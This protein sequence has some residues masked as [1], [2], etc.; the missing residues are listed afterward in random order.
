MVAPAAA[1]FPTLTFLRSGVV[2]W[3]NVASDKK[4]KILIDFLRI[5][6]IFHHE[7]NTTE[8]RL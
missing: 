7:R 3:L 2:N 4:I 6:T 8:N 1:G 5:W